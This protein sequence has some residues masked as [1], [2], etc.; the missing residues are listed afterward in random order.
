MLSDTMLQDTLADALCTIKNAERL[1]KGECTINASKLIREVLK[2][3]EAKSYIGTFEFVNDGKSGRYRVELA[4]KIID[5]NV[6]KPRFSVK[7]DEFDK[8]E[9]RFLPSRE[10]GMLIISTPKGVMD[11][12]KAKEINTGGKLLGFVY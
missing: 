7:V 1:G 12:R 9:K 2:L 3:L 8:W 5:C 4:K 10:L 6:I 11:H